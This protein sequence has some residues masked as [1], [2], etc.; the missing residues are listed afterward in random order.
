MAAVAYLALGIRMKLRR[1][2]LHPGSAAGSQPQFLLVILSYH[3]VSYR[4]LI[5]TLL[6][7]AGERTS[8]KTITSLLTFWTSR[9]IIVPIPI[10]P[11]RWTRR[12]MDMF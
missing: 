6:V 8:R 10:P 3:I 4:I 11:V 12:S 7:S 9:T 2:Q 1:L 5:P